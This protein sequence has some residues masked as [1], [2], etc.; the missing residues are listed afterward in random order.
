LFV[1]TT[2]HLQEIP[3]NAQAAQLVAQHALIMLHAHPANQIMDFQT[4]PVLFALTTKHLQ[5]IPAN[6]Q[7]AQLVAQH[8]L[9]MLHAHPANQIMAL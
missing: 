1:L 3:A 6:A 4:E 8:A 5:E 9:I 7:A 2:K